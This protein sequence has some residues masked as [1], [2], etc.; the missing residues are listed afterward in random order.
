MFALVLALTFA[1]QEAPPPPPTPPM[2]EPRPIEPRHEPPDAPDDAPWDDEDDGD[3]GIDVG[4][5]ADDD[6]TFVSESRLTFGG[7]LGAAAGNGLAVPFFGPGPGAFVTG[8]QRLLAFDLFYLGGDAGLS[9][10]I[11]DSGDF[12][13]IAGYRGRVSAGLSLPIDMVTF[14][15]ELHGGIT[16]IAVVPVPRMGL[17]GAVKLALPV[18][19]FMTLDAEG[20]ADVDFLV[21]VPAP[22]ASLEGGATL[23]LGDALFT[24]LRAG[25]EGDAVIALVANSV[26]ASVFLSVTLGLDLGLL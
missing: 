21:I 14:E 10:G 26:S 18:A 11:N 15:A 16:S 20:R 8:S 4:P 23:W 19:D 6:E 2:E 12:S 3:D 22:A 9:L 25:I 13:S 17:G 5:A 1:A 7:R 24:R